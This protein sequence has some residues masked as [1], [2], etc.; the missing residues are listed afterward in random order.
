MLRCFTALRG[1]FCCE[2]VAD[3]CRLGVDEAAPIRCNPCGAGS[4]RLCLSS[5]LDLDLHGT[6]EGI[7]ND[8]LECFR[9]DHSGEDM[10]R[11]RTARMFIHKSI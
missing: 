9:L 5:Q 2:L 8:A 10:R 3:R 7:E 6:R 1:G 4:D 11:L